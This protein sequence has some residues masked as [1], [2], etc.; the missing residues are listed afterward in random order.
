MAYNVFVSSMTQQPNEACIVTFGICKLYQERLLYHV[1]FIS[2]RN[3]VLWDLRQL[4][5]QSISNTRKIIEFQKHQPYPI[6]WQNQRSLEFQKQT[7][8]L[9]YWLATPRSILSPPFLPTQFMPFSRFNWFQLF[10]H[11]QIFVGQ[12]SNQLHIPGQFLLQDTF[13]ADNRCQIWYRCN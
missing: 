5:Y 13:S 2:Q 3:D 7:S 10:I 6:D 4:I 1:T 8:T 11:L 12:S 9:S